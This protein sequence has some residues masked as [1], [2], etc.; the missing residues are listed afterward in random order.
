LESE[1]Q[2][3]F[4]EEVGSNPTSSLDERVQVA[5]NL[6][7][8]VPHVPEHETPNSLSRASSSVKSY[9]DNDTSKGPSSLIDEL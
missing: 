2:D 5:T 7:S 8:S 4:V 1:Y 9:V 6:P 3:D